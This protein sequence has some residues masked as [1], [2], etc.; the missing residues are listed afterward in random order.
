MPEATAVMHALDPTLPTDVRAM[1]ATA[2]VLAGLAAAALLVAALSWAIRQPVFTI[3]AV[4]VEG[5]ISRN[6]AATL[7][8]HTVASLRGNFFT[9]DLVAV[10]R[11]F[12]AVPWVRKAVVNRIWPNRLSVRLEEHRA[13]ALWGDG[14]DQLVNSEGEVFAANLGD[15]EDDNLPTLQGPDGSSATMLALRRSLDPLLTPLGARIATLSLSGRGTWAIELDSGAVLE[16]GRGSESEVVQRTQ[17]FVG[18]VAGVIARYERPLVHAD[19]RHHQ[20]YAV[21]LKGI[22]TVTDVSSPRN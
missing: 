1:N 19:L 12:E 9:I 16:L 17:Q 5:E 4:R 15:L 18:T 6:N 20:G 21:R 3:R 2:L 13:A 8:A 11:A 22:S 7:Q 14:G 10:R